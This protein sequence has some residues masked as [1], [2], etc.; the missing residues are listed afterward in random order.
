[1]P[2]ATDREER[3]SRGTALKLAAIGAASL[4]IGFWR[5]TP[6]EA[7]EYGDCVEEC[8][9]VSDKTLRKLFRACEDVFKPEVL[10]DHYPG[11]KKVKFL[12]M[13]PPRVGWSLAGT[14]LLGYCYLKNQHFVDKWEKECNDECK[15]E[16]K[17]RA[18]QSASSARQVCKAPPPPKHESPK[19]PP[20]PNQSYDPCAACNAVGGLC[21]GPFKPDPGTGRSEACACANPSLGCERYGCK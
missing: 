10:Y 12:A 2:L 8:R 16:C 3:Y 19:P 11:W 14:T 18:L 20:P 21:C 4:S 7:G 6:A 13:F 15:R 5:T 1:V 17:G 9:K